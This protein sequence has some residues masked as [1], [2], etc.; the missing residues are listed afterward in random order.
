MDKSILTPFRL[1]VME[2]SLG[3]YG[4]AVYQKGK[5]LLS[6]YWRSNDRLCLYSG[7]KTFTAT[8]I[9]ICE[10]EGRL[11]I[12][13]EILPYFPEYKDIAAP[14][15]EKITIRDLLHMASGKEISIDDWNKKKNWAEVFFQSPMKWQP[16]EHFHYCNACTYMLSRIVEKVSGVTLREYLIPR[17]FEPMNIFNPQWSVC[18]DGHTI[19]ASEL[20]LN[21]EEFARI[22]ILYL[23]G[24]V[25]NGKRLVSEEYIKKAT[26][27]IIEN[28]YDVFTDAENVNGYGYQLWLCSREGTYRAD[29]MYAQHCIVFPDI[30]AVV[31]ITAHNEINGNDIIRAVYTDLVPLLS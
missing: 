21:T 11:K 13:D 6:H 16:G 8:G 23:N 4:I 25:Y 18:P 22:G 20:Y 5:E 19:G 9:G 24:G 10:D 12:T 1:T 7:S 15:T 29:G 31:T 14:G 26:T 3:V 27:D 30:E 28:K 17:L 2:R